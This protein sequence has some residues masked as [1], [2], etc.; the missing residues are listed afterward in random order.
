MT[1]MND[2]PVEL[3]R[4]VPV[5]VFSTSGS[6]QAASDANATTA[7]RRRIDVAS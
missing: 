1:R 2:E 3:P 6:E 4:H 5:T 7:R